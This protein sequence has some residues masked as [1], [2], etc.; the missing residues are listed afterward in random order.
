MQTLYSVSCLSK[1]DLHI[2]RATLPS[3]SAK[4]E[5]FQHTSNT[6]EVCSPEIVVRD[7]RECLYIIKLMSA[8]VHRV[9][10]I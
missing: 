5:H 6:L 10:S 4:Q 3:A 9:I 2:I 7:G 1:F 8:C